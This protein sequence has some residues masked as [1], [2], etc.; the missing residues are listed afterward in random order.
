MG[1]IRIWRPGQRLSRALAG[2]PDTARRAR[3]FRPRVE[4]LEDRVQL[5][6]TLL[7]LSVVGL[8]APSF[9]SWNAHA[10]GWDDGF[11]ARLDAADLLPGDFRRAE[12]GDA[13]IDQP[14]VTPPIAEPAVGTAVPILASADALGGQL[15]RHQQ[16]SPTLALLQELPVYFGGTS[17]WDGM[18]W[19]GSG[20]PLSPLPFQGV[21]DGGR[22][23]GLLA[24]AG[25]A[26]LLS[27]DGSTGQ[28]VIRADAGE[29]TVREGL[30]ADGF[31]EVTLDG[32][33][34][35][36]NPRS[37][38]FDSGLAGATDGTVAGVRFDGGGQ[39]TLIVGSQHLP[40]SLTVQA[41]GATVITQDV[42]AGLPTAGGA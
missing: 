41:T 2:T 10:H 1:R 12:A 8:W 23:A 11:F 3:T 17:R 32:Q 19:G 33:P 6:D 7:G 9:T 21:G 42:H 24:A 4:E 31:V 15:A 26:S 29:H 5:G 25:A 22:S 16:A 14:A 38:A 36:S 39:S 30:G 35:S 28:L 20:E 18:L 27:F 40:R 34:H 37:A 13:T